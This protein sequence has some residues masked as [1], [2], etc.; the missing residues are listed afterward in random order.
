[1]DWY[2]FQ[3]MKVDR[4]V[5]TVEANAKPVTLGTHRAQRYG[6]HRKTSDLRPI[7]NSLAAVKEFA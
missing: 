6:L 2:T 3:R 5:A 4:I 1:M 7:T